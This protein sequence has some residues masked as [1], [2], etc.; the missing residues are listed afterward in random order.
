[1]EKIDVCI[2]GAGPSGIAT[3]AALVKLN[4]SWR[5]HLVIL[6]KAEPPRHGS[7][8]TPCS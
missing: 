5:D 6:E 7:G 8:L 2:I 1:M 3:A 4:P